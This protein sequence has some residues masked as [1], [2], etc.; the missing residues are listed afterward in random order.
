MA[1]TLRGRSLELCNCTMYCPCWLGPNGKPDQGWCGGA[2]A[3]EIEQGASDGVDLSGCVVALGAWW[4][5]NFFGGEGTGRLYIDDGASAEQQR[6]L[7][8]I[9]SG[10][11]GGAPGGVFAGV[12]STW[13][14]TQLTK[15]SVGWGDTPSLTVGDVGRATLDPVKNPLG[16]AAVI[17][18]T[19]VQ[20]GLQLGPVTLASGQ[21]SRWTDA[22]LRTWEGDSGTLHTFDWAA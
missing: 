13:L 3:W 15:V 1:W 6:E 17:T 14:P 12:I 2:F 9:F 4:P 22:D 11:K 16:E 18:G 10:K 21:G 19:P 7:E 20:A 8:A 5:G